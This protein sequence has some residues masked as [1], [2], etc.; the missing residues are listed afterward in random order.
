MG[1]CWEKGNGSNTRA[2][3]TIDSSYTHLSTAVHSSSN[4]IEHVFQHDFHSQP[5]VGTLYPDKKQSMPLA[6]VSCP[7]HESFIRLL[8]LFHKQKFDAKEKNNLLI[9]PA[10]FDP[11]LCENHDRAR[12]NIKYMQNL[13]LDFEKVICLPMNFPT[14]FPI[15][16]WSSATPIPILPTIPAFGS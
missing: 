9:S 11:S 5:C 12:E 2:K 1:E 14:C 15:F 10:I 16:G 3:T 7:D 8:R 6:Y 4:W 13:W